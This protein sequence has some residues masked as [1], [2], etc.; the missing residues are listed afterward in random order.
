M[1]LVCTSRAA[2]LL[3]VLLVLTSS[4]AMAQTAAA[5]GTAVNA[6]A[7]KDSISACIGCHAIPGY[8]A[9][10]PRVYRVP[11]IAGQ[12]VKY[13]E[14]ALTAYKRGERNHPTMTA[15]AKGL[16]DQ[17]IQVIAA[18]YASLGSEAP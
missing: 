4:A 6:V 9:S 13:I 5:P 7:A 3:A 12:S 11:M 15:I 14:V 18:Y 16:S 17:Q 10:F 8:Q 1:K 2:G